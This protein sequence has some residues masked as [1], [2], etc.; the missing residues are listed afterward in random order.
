MSVLVEMN[1]P[2]FCNLPNEI[3]YMI[4]KFVKGQEE[5]DYQNSEEAFNIYEDRRDIMAEIRQATYRIRDASFAPNSKISSKRGKYG[6]EWSVRNQANNN[7]H[8][9]N[10][11]RLISAMMDMG[12]FSH[13]DPEDYDSEFESNFNDIDFSL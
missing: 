3:A 10:S 8:G 6:V 13:P 1:I 7:N 12:D 11:L 5:I 9:L 2:T 4:D